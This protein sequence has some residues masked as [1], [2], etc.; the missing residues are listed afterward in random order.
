[1]LT[2]EG[3]VAGWSAQPKFYQ[4]IG[5]S[6]LGSIHIIIISELANNDDFLHRKPLKSDF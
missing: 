6:A 4:C 3:F 1:M 5:D 2:T